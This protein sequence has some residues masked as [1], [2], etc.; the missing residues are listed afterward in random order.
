MISNNN[1]K[2]VKPRLFSPKSNFSISNKSVLWSSPDKDET[3]ETERSL[4]LIP[5]KKEKTKIIWSEGG[6]VIYLTGTFCNWQKLYL[7]KKDEKNK[8]YYKLDLPKGVHQ[9]K[10]KVDGYWKNS[11]FYPTCKV[12]GHIYN[13]LDNSRVNCENSN[14]STIESSAISGSNNPNNLQNNLHNNNDNVNT[15]IDSKF[16]FYMCSKKYCNYYPKNGE[17][18]EFTSKK[19]SYFYSYCYHGV[20]EIQNNIGN[21]NYLILKEK[22]I[23]SGN[24]SYK[25]IERKDHILLN[26][27]CQKQINGGHH[28]I[29]SVVIKYRHKNSTF[30]YYT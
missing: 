14:I 29:N 5:R 4:S 28:T 6:K 17:M 27:I 22:D 25:N 24:Y 7:M 16:N 26:H 15:N 30:L 11:S 1:E 23:L 19:P 9:F 3:N 21:K 12:G 20:N 2:K 8:F 13:Y 10:F 18:D